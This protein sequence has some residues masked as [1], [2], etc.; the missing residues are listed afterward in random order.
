MLKHMKAHKHLKPGEKGTRRLVDRFGDTL[1]CVR[2]R[3]DAIRDMRIKT[4]E[5]IVDEKPGRGIPRI[6]ESDTVLVQVPFTMR[7]LRDRL[8]G[9]GAK[10]DPDQKLWRVRWGLI[11]GDTELMER[12]VKG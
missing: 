2:Y 7:A 5:I 11:R 12:V 10:W 3:Y 8:K 4:A 6:R 9:V 1:L